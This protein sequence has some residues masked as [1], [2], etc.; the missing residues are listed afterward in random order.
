MTGSPLGA[1]HRAVLL[2]ALGLLAACGGGGALPPLPA[3]AEVDVPGFETYTTDHN[4]FARVRRD[5]SRPEDAPILAQFEDADPADPAGYRSLIALNDE[6]YRGRVVLEVL[7]Q[8]AEGDGAPVTRLLRLTAD[9]EPFRNEQ[10]G[11]L[12]AASG[13]FHLRG[14]NFAWVTIDD[15][16]VLSGQDQR[17][18]TDMVLDFDSQTASLSLRTGVGPESQVRTEIQAQ[19]LPFNIRTGAYGGEMLVTV[20]DPDGP[21]VLETGGV[22]RGSVG[23]SPTYAGGQHGLSTG[24]LYLAEGEDEATGRRLRIHGAFAGLDPNALP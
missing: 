1:A 17:G 22:L 7:A 13:Q 20:W 4:G 10:N 19:D 12:A 9:T 15:G 16:P 24:G 6:L 11:R 8:V 23:G 14:Q 3:G 2:A 18:L 5:D 21:D